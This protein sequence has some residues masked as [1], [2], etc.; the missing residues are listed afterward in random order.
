MI[1]IFYFAF[2]PNLYAFLS[3]LTQS[4]IVF[5]ASFVLYKLVEYFITKQTTKKEK[6][7]SV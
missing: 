3:Y 6:P 4:I 5:F 1:F 2:S 7:K